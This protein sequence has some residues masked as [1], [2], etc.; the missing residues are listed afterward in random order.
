MTDHRIITGPSELWM[1][2]P[3]VC[4]TCEHTH[5]DGTEDIPDAAPPCPRCGC[6]SF[7]LHADT[8]GAAAII[9][10]AEAGQD[11]IFDG[12]HAVGIADAVKQLEAHLFSVAGWAAADGIGVIRVSAPARVDT[13]TGEAIAASEVTTEPMVAPMQWAAEGS[14]GANSVGHLLAALAGMAQAEPAIFGG[15]LDHSGIDPYQPIFGWY[16][17]CDY[18]VVAEGDHGRGADDP[19]VRRA[20]VRDMVA[21]DIDGRIYWVQRGREWVGGRP[22][23]DAVASRFFPVGSAPC[24]V[25]MAAPLLRLAQLARRQA[26]LLAE[27]RKAMNAEK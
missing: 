11:P 13:G 21:A 27:L 17:L 8:I 23:G 18:F 1:G 10:A 15:L 19:Q 20:E 3:Q 24:P 6:T 7:V 12:A 5:A 4:G 16:G 22:G 14:I 9:D 25:P 2:A 26:E